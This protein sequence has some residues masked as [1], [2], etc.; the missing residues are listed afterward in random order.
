M[1]GGIPIL[2]LVAGLAVMAGLSVVV[3]RANQEHQDF[4]QASDT[5]LLTIPTVAPG[6]ATTTTVASD[7]PT[8]S[9]AATTVAVT[10]EAP[11]TTATTTPTTTAAATTA[12][13]EA[14]TTTTAPVVEATTV[15]PTEAPPT[16][17]PADG[18][19]VEI[20]SRVG[21][22]SFGSRCLI[23]GFKLSGFAKAPTTFVCEFADGSRNTFRMGVL[24]VKQACSTSKLPD[25]ITIE[26]DGVRSETVTT[27]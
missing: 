20:N 1:A 7:T 27:G 18:R 5:P 22:C 14:P 8:T 10:T 24:E 3:V 11:T 12:P 2:V 25:R 21:A 13:T 19:V 15:A 16:T 26:V 23:A 17:R 4:V 9:T 6:A